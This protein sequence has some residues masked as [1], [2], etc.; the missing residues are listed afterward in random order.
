MIGLLWRQTKRGK[1]L[2]K[3]VDIW[4]SKYA[5]LMETRTIDPSGSDRQVPHLLDSS[6]PCHG[7]DLS[8]VRLIYAIADDLGDSPLRAAR[9]PRSFLFPHL[10]SWN[11]T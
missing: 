3:D 8:L 10:S 6:N 7:V 4:E 9:I 11:S 5:E 2:K 1:S